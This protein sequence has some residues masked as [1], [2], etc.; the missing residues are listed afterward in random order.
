MIALSVTVFLLLTSPTFAQLPG[1]IGIFSEPN[2]TDCN[3]YD[4]TSLVYVYMV[5]VYTD[6]ATGARFKLDVSGTGWTHL[7]DA[8]E[9]TVL[10]GTSTSGVLLQYPY[11]DSHPVLLGFASFAGGSAPICTEI[12][13]V[14]H[15]AVASGRIEATDCQ[16]RIFYPTGGRG[17]A[18]PLPSCSCSVPVEETTWGAIKGQYR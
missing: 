18:S 4:F 8:W 16:G 9:V 2:L 10:D 15:P 14:A 3:F 6:G 17:V 7:S 13:I 1:S 11:C 12:G 5:H